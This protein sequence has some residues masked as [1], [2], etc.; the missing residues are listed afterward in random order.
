MAMEARGKLPSQQESACLKVCLLDQGGRQRE[1]C[2]QGKESGNARILGGRTRASV[3]QSWWTRASVPTSQA[4]VE[5]ERGG[6]LERINIA[7]A[8]P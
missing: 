8:G 2:V 7:F 6:S 5:L 4:A 3:D 1:E